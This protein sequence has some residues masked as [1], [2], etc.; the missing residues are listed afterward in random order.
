MITTKALPRLR[1]ELAKKIKKITIE[2]DGKKRR[3]SCP[4]CDTI[5]NV[6]LI[7]HVRSAHPR[8]WEEWTDE[9]VRLYEVLNNR[10]KK[11]AE[12]FSNSEGRRLFT[13]AVVRKE[14]FKKLAVGKKVKIVG[15]DAI[16][17]WEPT[18]DEYPGF[19]DT[20]W[21]IPKRG[22]WGV[23][24]PTY[25]GNWAPQ[26]PRALIELYTLPGQLVV[27]PFVGGGTTLLEAWALGRHAIGY[28]VADFAIEVTTARLAE[29]RAKA[30][31]DSLFG[32]RKVNVDV[33]RGDARELK[34]IE[35]NSVDLIA[36]HPPYG[37]ALPYTHKHSADLSEISDPK[38]F[39]DEIEKAGERWFEVLKPGRHCAILIGDQR[40]DG[41]LRTFG[42]ETLD[43]FRRLGWVAENVIIKTQHQ[44]TS[45]NYY[46]QN[47][48]AIRLRLS[49]EYLLVFRKPA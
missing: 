36:A 22:T 40:S 10:D 3:V 24:Q 15:K 1:P 39:M 32:L 27:D 29:M 18:Q 20:V 4:Y 9:M 33:R 28:D 2:G 21:D 12:S 48:D 8:E 14:I 47:H 17:R 35:R 46:W 16:A 30:A 5:A 13:P 6:N 11:V 42:F 26:I 41:I 49:H 31:K 38:R 7:Q 34:G 45:T 19:Q 23:H 43:R 44:D 25:R 37:D